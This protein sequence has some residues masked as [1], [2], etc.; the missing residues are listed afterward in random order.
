MRCC[1]TQ[2]TRDGL[3]QTT[4]VVSPDT[5]TAGMTYDAAGNLLSRTDSRGVL[6]Q[7]SYDNLDR[8]TSTVLSQ[9]G[10]ANQTYGWTYDQTGGMYTNG[11]GR[12]TSI[13]FPEGSSSYA[14]DAQGRI[15][16]A[17]QILT[18]NA[19][20]NPQAVVQYTS[21]AYD[22]AGNL[23][24]LTYPSGRVLNITY[25]NGLPTGLTLA[26]STLISDLQFAPF[27]GPQS[28]NW[29]MAGGRIAHAR[30]FDTSGRLVRYPLG[31]HLRD[32]NYDAANRISGYTHYVAATGATTGSSA[33]AHNQQFAYDALGRLTQATTSQATWSYTYDANGNRTSVA[34]NSGT[35]NTYTVDPGSNRLTK[36][37]TPAITL[38]HDAMG[39]IVSDGTYTM[40][41]ELRGRLATASQGGNVTTYAYDNAGQRVRKHN[42]QGTQNTVIFVYDPAGQLL[43]EYDS[44]GAALREYVWLGNMPVAMFMPDPAQG[45]NAATAPPLV[46]YIHADHLNT[47]RVL[48]DQSNTMRWRWMSEP[49]GTTAPDTSPAGQAALTFNLRF[50]GQY[51]D[52]ETGLFYNYQRDYIAG[53]GRYAQSDPIG[54]AGGMNPYAYVSG[55]PILY[56]DP[57]GLQAQALPMLVP[58]L[59]VGCAITSACRDAIMNA[60]T[61]SK[62]GVQEIPAAKTVSEFCPDCKATDT[63]SM[64]QSKA[65]SWAGITPG[66]SSPIPWSIFNPPGGSTFK[67]GPVWADFMRNNL[68][69]S[70]FGMSGP[71]GRLEEHPFGHPDLPGGLNHDCP[72]FVAVNSAGVSKEFPYQPGSQ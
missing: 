43:G 12:L 64:A 32:L 44:T 25:A 52:S 45:A 49:F 27:G 30:V 48:V 41:Y 10:Q 35:P 61:G 42:N 51:F 19:S 37:A 5:G 62:A 47:P 34:I 23:T 50:P 6:A 17:R 1:T 14:Y 22:S 71:S 11:M 36:L 58:P 63:R 66:N 57:L 39:N 38:T 28:W 56:A 67:K 31:E 8:L 46:Y 20:A 65:Y 55:A 2:Y 60:M 29:V 72:H 54:L 68:S 26:G 53:I 70:N 21:Y 69:P 16:L 33:P 13:T 59:I 7:H 40:G 9:P 18:P 3:G 24:S 15:T 4:Q